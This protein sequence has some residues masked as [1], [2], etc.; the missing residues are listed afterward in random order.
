MLKTCRRCKAQLPHEQFTKNKASADGLDY[1]CLACKKELN[2]GFDQK[3]YYRANSERIKG[4]ARERREADP[5]VKRARDA[6]YRA[7][8]RERCVDAVRKWSAENGD[9]KAAASAA[10]AKRNPDKVRA[11][12]ARSLQRRL[13]KHAAYQAKRRAAVGQACPSWADQGL[14]AE[15]YELAR[16]RT[17]ATG[18]EWHVD[19]IAPLHSELVCGLHVETNLRVIPGAQNMAKSNRFWPDMPG[20]KQPPR[21]GFFLS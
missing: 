13:P 16:L 14:I 19:H 20:Q 5:A 18:I 2:A 7:A 4:Q 17:Q 21:G 12:R 1:I 6:A 3:A 11:M 15:I 9:R 8:H 10:W